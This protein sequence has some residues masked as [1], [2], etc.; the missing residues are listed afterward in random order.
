MA[1]ANSDEPI[2]G[3][4]A[5]RF[6]VEAGNGSRT[7]VATTPGLAVEP[8]DRLDV[9]RRATGRWNQSLVWH[10]EALLLFSTSLP[11]TAPF[12]RVERI[13]PVTLE[14]IVASPSLATGGHIWE[15]GCLAHRNGDIYVV[16]GCF[17]YRLNAALEVV[18]QMEMPT[19]RPYDSIVAMDD[20][21][22]I[23]KDMQP[24]GT[25]SRFTVV[26]AED[27]STVMELPIPE[28]T[29]GKCCVSG[30]DIYVPGDYSI[31]RFRYR[32]SKLSRDTSWT[33]RYRTGNDGHGHCSDLTVSGGYVWVHDNAD[34][35][36]MVALL[37]TDPVGSVAPDGAFH[38]SFR[39]PFRLHRFSTANASDHVSIEPFVFAGWP[40]AGPT[41]VAEHGIVLTF[42]SLNGGLAAHQVADDGS[43]REL[44]QFPIRTRWQPLVYADTAEVVVDDVLLFDD[45]NIVVLDLFTGRQKARTRSGT[46][47]PSTGRPTPGAA[48]DMYYVSTPS[49]ARVELIPGPGWAPPTPLTSPPLTPPLPPPMW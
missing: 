39:T 15:G 4:L 36:E 14:T 26:D 11:G 19:T 2:S 27:L 46:A 7:N 5:S 42:D 43:M 38:Q 30:D 34:T 33:G 49:I 48:R 1:E 44:W 23:V 6:P 29:L 31:F 28:A 8:G 32:R 10:D 41:Y 37:Q 13:D 40:A 35:E 24:S 22:L 12:S 16:T 20:G 3:Y 45:D 25:T 47:L 9:L 18:G 17:L 21:R